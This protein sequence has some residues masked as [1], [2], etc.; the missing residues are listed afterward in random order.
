[1]QRI[2]YPDAQF[3]SDGRFAV[4]RTWPRWRRKGSGRSSPIL[5]EGELSQ[6]PSAAEEAELAAR[7]QAS[8][9]ATFRRPR[10]RCSAIAWWRAWA[11]PLDELEGP[12]L[13]H[14]ASGLRSAIAWAAAAARSQPADCVIAALKSAGFD[15][16]ALREELE[17]QRG[18]RTQRQFRRPSIAAVESRRR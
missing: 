14:C 16:A 4:A 12:V 9:F 18:R 6:Y 8:A 15:L 7:P 11:G 13:A 5:P 2:M 17:D 1:M 3:R 10:A